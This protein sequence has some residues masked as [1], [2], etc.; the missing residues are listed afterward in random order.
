[1]NELPKSKSLFCMIIFAAGFIDK[2]DQIITYILP[3]RRF[4]FQVRNLTLKIEQETQKRCLTQNDLKM[5]TQQVNTL[6]MSEKQLK[7]ENNHLMEMKM[8]LEKQN[9]ELRK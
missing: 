9:A 2:K 7:Q 3:S 4:I 6:K 1:M 5:Q 8:S